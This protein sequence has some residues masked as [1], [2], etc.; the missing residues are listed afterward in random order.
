MKNLRAVLCVAVIL[1][2]GSVALADAAIKNV[3]FIVS[4]DLKASVLG[5]YGDEVCKTPNIDRLAREGMVFERAYCQGTVCAP[6]RRSFM[7]SRYADTKG[8]NLGEHLKRHGWYSARV[9][10]IYHM[11]VPGD[12]ITGTRMCEASWRH[13]PRKA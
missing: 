13:S 6:S 10:K 5:C 7:Y 12:I 1:M 3:L 8:V 2:S 11:R 9:G 4:D